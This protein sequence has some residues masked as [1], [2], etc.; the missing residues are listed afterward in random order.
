MDRPLQ[1]RRARFAE[2]LR[3]AR[4]S[5]ARG[6]LVAVN[7][8]RD[9]ARHSPDGKL[10]DKLD[11]LVGSLSAQ[12]ADAEPYRWE[13]VLLGGGETLIERLDHRPRSAAPGAPVRRIDDN[14]SVTSP[15]AL[16]TLAKVVSHP[17]RPLLRVREAARPIEKVQ[18]VGQAAE[19]PG[20]V[21]R[22]WK[23]VSIS[24]TFAAFDIRR[25]AARRVGA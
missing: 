15:V 24:D 12:Q 1:A 3:E 18:E 5:P 13:S 16:E 10:L 22:D 9:H 11:G 4:S 25:R 2:S 14:V 7:R 20:I 21:A 19:A 6:R 17:D 23:G 8:K